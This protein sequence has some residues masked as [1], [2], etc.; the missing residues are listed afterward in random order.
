MQR[1]A[2]ARPLDNYRLQVT[3]EDGMAGVVSL[4]ERLFGPVFEPLRDLNVFAQV[5]VDELGAV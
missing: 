5:S 1:V 4:K 3:F 2:S